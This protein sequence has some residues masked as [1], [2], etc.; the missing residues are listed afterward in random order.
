VHL[1]YSHACL[2]LDVHLTCRVHIYATCYIL[3]HVSFELL[4]VLCEAEGARCVAATHVKGAP[5]FAAVGGLNSTLSLAVQV[6]LQVFF[7]H[8]RR[9]PLPVQFEVLA[10]IMLALHVAYIF[11]A[12]FRRAFRHGRH[13]GVSV[14]CDPIAATQG[15]ATADAVDSQHNHACDGTADLARHYHCYGD[16]D[17]APHHSVART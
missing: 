8:P 13:Q 12:I 14:H 3:F 5:R 6:L 1:V 16:R 17:V 11:A 9:L 10:A 4:R 7:N 15:S 2:V